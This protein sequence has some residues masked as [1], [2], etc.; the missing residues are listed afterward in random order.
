MILSNT[1]T[2]KK[3]LYFIGARII[4]SIKSLPY[5]KVCTIELYDQYC[6][7]YE[8]VSFTYFM[9]ALDWLF[10]ASILDINDV[11]ELYLCS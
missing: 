9:L 3:S 11:G 5:N 2:P 6:S 7:S 8:K 10:I 1:Q 4:L